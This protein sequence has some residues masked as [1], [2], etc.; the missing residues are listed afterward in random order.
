MDE[1]NNHLILPKSRS[2]FDHIFL[3]VI[4]S[5]IEE[6]IQDK[7]QTIARNKEGE[8]F[9]AELINAIRNIDTIDIL[10]RELLEE[11]V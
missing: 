7:Q 10:S 3:I 4:I 5:I 11:I 6:S 9:V 2:L 8:K 1:I